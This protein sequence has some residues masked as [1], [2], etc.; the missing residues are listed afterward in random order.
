[1]L[2]QW[3]STFLLKRNPNEKFQWLEKPLCNNLIALYNLHN[4]WRNPLTKLAEPWLKTTVIMYLN[5]LATITALT[6]TSY[7]SVRKINM[8]AD[9]GVTVRG[10][11]G[12]DC[13]RPRYRNFKAG[14]N[15]HF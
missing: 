8:F 7:A 13:F 5:N 9:K 2:L 3:F 14:Q 15:T 12:E 6:G 11:V 4:F 10:L 1:M